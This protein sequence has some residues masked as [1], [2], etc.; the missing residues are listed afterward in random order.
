MGGLDELVSTH[1]SSF[2]REFS[3]RHVNPD[4]AIKTQKLFSTD[5]F[6]K[7]VEYMAS[8]RKYE[9]LKAP[10]ILANIGGADAAL[11]LYANINQ[12]TRGKPHILFIDRNYSHIDNLVFRLFTAIL[13][14]GSRQNYVLD[15]FGVEKSEVPAGILGNG[16]NVEDLEKFLLLKKYDS[17]KHYNMLEEK[18]TN[19]LS[20]NSFFDTKLFEEYMHSLNTITSY[21]SDNSNYKNFVSGL[22]KNIKQNPKTHYLTNDSLYRTI[23]NMIREGKFNCHIIHGDVTLPDGEASIR[24]VVEKYNLTGDG[25]L[26]FDIAFIPDLKNSMDSLV[27]FLRKNAGDIIY[28]KL[29]P[30]TN[31]RYLDTEDAG[32]LAISA[33]QAPEMEK[34]KEGKRN[35]VKLGKT[36]ALSP[37]EKRKGIPPTLL[38]SNLDIGS[39]YCDENFLES[40]AEIAQGIGAERILIN[41]AIYGPFFFWENKRRALLDPEYPSLDAQLRRYAEW[42][43]PL[44]NVVHVMNDNDDKILD[45]L[46]ALYVNEYM[47]RQEGKLNIG[48]SVGWQRE[49]R[50][51]RWDNAKRVIKEYVYPFLLYLGEDAA[52]L[53]SEETFTSPIFELVSGFQR[54]EEGGNLR[55]EERALLQSNK[56][57]RDAFDATIHGGNEK[58]KV[59]HEYS[60]F[61]DGDNNLG[62]RYTGGFTFSKVTEYSN[63]IAVP[64][65]MV[66]R[67]QNGLLEKVLPEQVVADG[68]AAMF[69]FG[70]T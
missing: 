68:R 20:E 18:A 28:G 9:G 22:I 17:D 57:R 70:V 2:K 44:K 14:S 58:F 39:K 3:T 55:T 24:K 60:E 64:K 31:K 35:R 53:Y 4:T 33:S 13:N 65:Q 8:A 12:S 1:L 10:S 16:F 43:Q 11:S 6:D 27:P 21:L 7:T 25:T 61:F 29:D 26:P 32:N 30:L 37:A 66:L 15:L 23:G 54:L 40:M 19:K 47:R 38:L 46:N 41:G 49:Y 34:Y 51:S 67:S 52:G 50:N 5:I 42:R 48:T 59:V 45:D 36:I 63:P 69:Y 62:I 56:K